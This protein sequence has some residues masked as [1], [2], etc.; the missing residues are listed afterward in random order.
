MRR[1]VVLAVFVA[2]S[3]ASA[4]VACG[5]DESGTVGD[6]S[7]D[8]TVT[9]GGTDAIP[10]VP[11]DVPQACQTLDASACVNA[12]VPSGWTYAVI[13]PGD[14]SCPS[15][16][17]AKSTYLSNPAPDAGCL[18]GCTAS[19]TLDCSGTVH[20]GT[21][22]N[23]GGNKS[24]DFDAGNDAACIV[25]NWGD[26][27]ISIGPLP[28][29]KAT[30][31]Q[32]DASAPP[33]GWTATTQTACTPNCNADYCGAGGAFQ[34]C[35]VSSNATSCPAPFTK[36]LSP[37]GTAQQITTACTGCTCAIKDVPCTATVIP[38]TQNDCT[39]TINNNTPVSTDGSCPPPLGT[40]TNSFSYVPTVGQPQCAPTAG[41]TP[42]A[43][44]T[45]S[46]TVCCLP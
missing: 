42:S 6:G 5:L 3:C 14:V 23:C 33:P 38:Y 1:G 10:D 8:V 13:A 37:L 7:V 15:S 21:Q 4:F 30:N 24:F 22:A 44:F 35:I 12:A 18:C 29:A 31:A 2:V 36:Q 19:G 20:A 11:I 43:S 32:C 40:N 16:D 9:E 17:Y 27:H 26:Q 34:R 41:G 25:T 28:T 39:G 46:I 45:Q